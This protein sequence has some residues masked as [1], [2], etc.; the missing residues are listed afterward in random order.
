MQDLLRS[1]GLDP[2]NFYQELEMSSRFVDTHQ[3]VSYSNDHVSLHSHTFYEIL[4]CKGGTGVEYLVGSDRYRLQKGDIVFL[5]PGVSHRP[6]LQEQMTEPYV[7]DV[8]WFS[9]EFVSLIERMFPQEGSTSALRHGLLRT[10]GTHWESLG[11]LLHYGVTE[12]ERKQTGWETAL[13]GTVILFLS[14]LKRAFLEDTSVSMAA[15]K[16]ELLD[17]IV[18]YIEQNLSRHITLTDTA[19]AFYVSESTVS[20]IFR[21]KLGVSFYRFVTQRRLIAAKVLIQEGSIL[22]Q[23][24]EQVGFS[25]YSSFYRAFKQEYG[26]SPRQFRKL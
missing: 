10:V 20:H 7:R 17:R 2:S 9:T 15:E 8:L 21:N 23:V 14:R 26:I 13:M 18:T 22:E 1:I 16:P 5:P 3:D 6:I 12:A 11:D 24:A 25:D 19:K 4:Y